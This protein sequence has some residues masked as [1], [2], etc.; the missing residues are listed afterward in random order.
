MEAISHLL[1]NWPAER[2]WPALKLGFGCCQPTNRPAVIDAMLATR[3][4]ALLLLLADFLKRWDP[5]AA[6]EAINH[7]GGY[8]HPIVEEA[9]LHV[10]T[11]EN[12]TVRL[13]AL[14][15]LG[16]GGTR[17]VLPARVDLTSDVQLRD[18]A[19]VAIRKIQAREQIGDAGQ[20]S[21][22]EN[23]AMG[24]LTLAEEAGK[25]QA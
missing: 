3:D 20:I 1:K 2:T 18:A 11:D 22:A 17:D 8:G 23:Q 4:P 19:E 15:A 14:R 12:L 16:D 21:L 6:I 9:L 7:L 5:V 13:A 10:L 24:A 25:N